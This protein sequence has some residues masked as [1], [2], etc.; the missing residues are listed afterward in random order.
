IAGN[1]LTKFQIH[2]GMFA[3]VFL[4]PHAVNDHR[5]ERDQPAQNT[6]GAE[7]RGIGG[8]KPEPLPVGPQGGAVELRN[9]G[10]LHIGTHQSTS[11]SP[12]LAISFPN[13]VWERTSPKLCFG[14]RWATLP[15]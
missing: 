5:V 1:F 4:Q 3:E 6:D 7:Q 10:A 12:S 15:F 13:S 9:L 11:I 8:R 14:E 2:P